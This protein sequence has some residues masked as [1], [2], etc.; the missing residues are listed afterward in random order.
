MNSKFARHF[1]RV[2]K[3]VNS[4]IATACDLMYSAA[5]RLLRPRDFFVNISRKC[6]HVC[7]TEHLLFDHLIATAFCCVCRFPPQQLL[8]LEQESSFPSFMKKLLRILFGR[9]LPRIVKLSIPPPRPLPSLITPSSPSSRSVLLGLLVKVLLRLLARKKKFFGCQDLFQGSPCALQLIW[10]LAT[11]LQCCCETATEWSHERNDC[12]AP[13][14]G[15]HQEP[16]GAR[17]R[18]RTGN[19]P[20]HWSYQQAFLR[21]AW[22]RRF[23]HLEVQQ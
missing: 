4:L 21:S 14:Q 23:S 6:V 7:P 12:A 22:K 10:H 8:R 20:L 3:L 11:L 1:R 9:S 2:P 16:D 15:C 17:D 18:S 13:P 5:I 19:A